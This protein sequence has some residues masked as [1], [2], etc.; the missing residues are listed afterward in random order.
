M[1]ISRKLTAATLAA[2]LTM[3]VSGS[4]AA[5]APPPPE[6]KQFA[7]CAWE[8]VEVTDCYYAVFSSGSIKVGNKTIPVNNP[9]TFQGG[10]KESGEFV[11]AENGV[12]LS[13]TPQAVPG[14]LV[15]ITAPTSW[16]PPVQ[17][18]FNKLIA[19]EF[20][21]VNATV[22]L[23]APASAITLN[24]ENMLL[25]EGTAL[26]LPVKIKL[27]NAAF[28]SNCYIGS[29]A[30]PIQI[31]LT[32]G[33][34][35]SLTGTA[36]ALTFN[37]AATIATLSGIKLV[38]ETFAAPKAEGCGGVFST[39]VDPLVD[40]IFGLPSASGK[41]SATLEGIFQDASAEAMRGP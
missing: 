15:G 17:A 3:L 20:T 16:P 19:E 5:A 21:G 36:G 26:G 22:E 33:L 41:N 35:G 38:N 18:W 31:N 10:R 40:S 9:I 13:K 11:G 24:T 39:Y 4:V 32:T 37:G 27:D 2:T 30:A 23:A 34:S 25:E 29:N 12:T 7:Q 6:Y 28:G 1:R 14:G 8:D